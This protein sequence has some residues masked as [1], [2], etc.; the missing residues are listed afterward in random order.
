MSDTY[1]GI[2]ISGWQ[3]DLTDGGILTRGGVR[4]VIAKLTEAVNR[5]SIEL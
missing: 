5:I 1:S 3:I 4:F 2:D